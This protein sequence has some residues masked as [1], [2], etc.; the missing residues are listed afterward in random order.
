[1][2]D[3][4]IN[5]SNGIL[6][7]SAKGTSGYAEAGKR[8]LYQLYKQGLNISWKQF[9]VDD[10][11]SYLQD[12]IYEVLQEYIDKFIEFDTA[13]FCCTPELWFNY[14]EKYKIKFIN[15][16][17]IGYTTWE[18][19]KLPELWVKYCNLMDEIWVPSQF[20]KEI[21]ERCGVDIPIKVVPYPSIPCSIS[22]SDIN[23]KNIKSLLKN[24]V[25][26]GN[27]NRIFEYGSDWKIYYTIG[28]WNVRKNIDD[29]VK[30]FCESFTINDKVKLIIKTFYL[31][32]TTKNKMYCINKLE[33]ILK[34]YPNHPEIV[35]I[36]DNVSN[37]EI[38]F[39]HLFGDCF[40]SLT[41]G[42]G[43][44]IGAFDSYNSDKHVII[45]GF[46]GHLEFLK[47]GYSGLID[48][49]LIPVN[50]EERSSIYGGD[51]K[52]ANPNI[53]KAVDKI[54]SFIPPLKKNIP[55]IILKEL[56]SASNFEHQ[57]PID[58][59][60]EENDKVN[61]IKLE[62]KDDSEF[63]GI[64][65]IGQYGTS[66]Y[67]TAAKGNLVYFFTKGIPVTWIPLY[68]DNSSMNEECYYNAMVK[69]LIKKPIKKHNTVIIHSTPDIWPEIRQQNKDLM[70]GKK[71]IGY[72]VWETSRLP[73][74][75]VE[76]INDTVDEVWC[77]SNYNL[78]VFK[79]S[80][81]NIPIKVFPHVFMP[82]DLPLK[83]QV[84]LKSYDGSLINNSNFYTFY[85]ISELNTRKGVDDLVNV[86][87]ESFTDKDPVQLILKMH[88]KNYEEHNK[89]YCVDFIKN[90]MSKYNNPPKVYYL[91]DN[92]TEREILGLH[93]I[94]DCYI[95]LC[96]SEGFGLT[97][98]E[99][100]KYGK[101]VI[102][103]G[104]GGCLDFL[105]KEYNGLVNYNID[106]IKGMD[107]FS[108]YYSKDQQWAYPDL[109]H[110]KSLIK[111][112]GK[113][114]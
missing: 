21:F 57:N 36:L 22:Y 113:N 34:N 30:T 67:A 92:L 71:V 14:I 2:E 59:V 15:K 79:N 3:I 9:V 91:L 75:W 51:Q 16:K 112:Y 5:N 107:T 102:T 50:F 19:N 18:T 82:K 4:P 40:I 60:L 44:C 38:E 106:N 20:N 68:F 74:L 111:K 80:G 78:E 10:S 101:K 27:T 25:W 41:R 11:Q 37:K 66:G 54:K 39:L 98:F 95:S 90:I 64:T 49:E 52:W 69:S 110:A 29:T 65:Y 108:K 72:T 87:C 63:T 77:P 48:Y 42:E 85:N 88:Y 58:I 97:I 32:Y 24:V 83:K 105:G 114:V 104:Y 47:E 56:V 76:C 81:V 46:G 13:I 73:D 23:E 8:I 96:K 45:T 94:G 1:M 55:N 99:A 7:H 62:V 33:S 89:K 100:F 17:L 93:S 35:L 109:N 28:E 26:Y 31:D 86:F 43:F 103:T 6:F 84:L 61:S 53:H 70:K 12:S